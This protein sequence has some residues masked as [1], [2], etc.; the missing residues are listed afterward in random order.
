MKCEVNTCT[1]WIPG[2]LCAAG[3]IDIL[4]EEEGKMSRLAEQTECKTF[5]RRRGLANIM[6]SIDNVNWGGMLSEPLPAR[7]AA[8][9]HGNLRG[10]F[11][12]VLVNRQPL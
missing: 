7:P 2:D 5:Y 11:V 6:G 4:N 9:P 12:P 1:H 3:N 10:G 8:D